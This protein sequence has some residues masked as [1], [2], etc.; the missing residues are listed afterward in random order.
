MLS[1]EGLANR[2]AIEFAGVEKRK[3][4]EAS[5]NSSKAKLKQKKQEMILITARMVG[6]RRI[7]GEVVAKAAVD[8]IRVRMPE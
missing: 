4:S 3:T 6:E 2:D 5:P 8:C 1:Q 7:R